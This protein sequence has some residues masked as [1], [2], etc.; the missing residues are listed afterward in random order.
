LRRRQQ[1]CGVRQRRCPRY[2]QGDGIRR[3]RL[4]DLGA[5]PPTLRRRRPG[6]A[7]RGTAWWWPPCPGPGTAAASA[8]VRGPGRLAGHALRSDRGRRAHAHRL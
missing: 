5:V 7:A 4:L 3:W 1:R 8:G 2:D 6:S